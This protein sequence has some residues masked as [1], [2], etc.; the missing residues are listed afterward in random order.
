M[1]KSRYR[2]D[3]EPVELFAYVS[4]LFGDDRDNFV[5]LM[6]TGWAL[7]IWHKTKHE[8]VLMVAYDVPRPYQTALSQ[9]WKLEPVA[10]LRYD[11]LV[12]VDSKPQL[13]RLFMKLRAFQMIKYS[14]VFFLDADILI[15]K[16]LDDVFKLP[17]PAGVLYPNHKKQRRLDGGQIQAENLVK[18][19]SDGLVHLESRLNAGALLLKP[20]LLTFA[21]VCKKAEDTRDPNPIPASRCPEEELLTRYFASGCE[22]LYTLGIRWNLELWRRKEVTKE[23]IESALIFHFSCTW[24]KPWWSAWSRNHEKVWQEMNEWAAQKAKDDPYDF[25]PRATAEWAFAFAKCHQWV[26]VKKNSSILAIASEAREDIGGPKKK[27]RRACTYENHSP[28]DV[29]WEYDGRDKH[30]GV[31]YCGQCWKSWRSVC[32]CTPCTPCTTV[33][34]SGQHRPLP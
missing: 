24:L 29:Y 13:K 10:E 16:Q 21:A 31:S 27:T 34:A 25:L 14:K 15:R 6:L 20:C 9:F 5:G 32:W 11:H 26:S 2:S 30:T 4:L 18:K 1:G 28:D 8:L 22:V 12:T 19:G 3:T 17:A 7:K 33:S 23:D